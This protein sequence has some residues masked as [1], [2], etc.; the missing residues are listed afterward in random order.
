[1]L[2]PS[3]EVLQNAHARIQSDIKNEKKFYD[4]LMVLIELDQLQQYE[5]ILRE[6]PTIYQH[7]LYDSMLSDLIKTRWYERTIMTMLI[8]S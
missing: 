4:N 7:R 1:M 6:H 5:K 3:A 8:M 2:I